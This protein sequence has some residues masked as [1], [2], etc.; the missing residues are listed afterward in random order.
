MSGKRAGKS[1]AGV[2]GHTAKR[3]KHTAAE[4]I[5]A[6]LPGTVTPPHHREPANVVAG[7]GGEPSANL[8][9]AVSEGTIWEPLAFFSLYWGDDALQPIVDATNA[10]ASLEK[11]RLPRK[12]KPLSILELRRFIGLAVFMRAVGLPEPFTYWAE[13]PATRHLSCVFPRG[14]LSKIR[15]E[16]IEG[17]LHAFLPPEPSL[18]PMSYTASG[19]AS[20]PGAT[21]DSAA[22]DRGQPARAY[23]RASSVRF[24]RV[25]LKE[26]IPGY[27]ESS[28]PFPSNPGPSRSEASDP[29]ASASEARSPEACSPDP[30][31]PA[32]PNPEPLGLGLEASGP[33][34]SSAGRPDPEPSNSVPPDPE[35]PS[36]EPP[37]SGQTPRTRIR[38][39][40]V[41]KS[42]AVYFSKHRHFEWDRAKATNA[43]ATSACGR[44]LEEHRL[45]KMDKRRGCIVCRLDF[46]DGKTGGRQR[47]KLTQFECVDCQPAT[48]VCGPK[49][50]E[51]WNRW[52]GKA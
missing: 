42:H 41:K 29:E 17:C 23:A 47:P 33:E 6:A 31:S 14:T 9:V 43:A 7:G 16:E 26:L 20:G 3:Q 12:W 46:S 44:S 5:S 22:A 45:E 48:A 35:V 18:G 51:C 19:P 2:S 38:R 24:R 30:S 8:E 52:H 15:Y 36:P 13:S 11:Q 40:Y 1:V 10:Y 27:M 32:Q 21:V 50:G 39:T 28:N 25:S 34:V 4:P 49:G 37:T